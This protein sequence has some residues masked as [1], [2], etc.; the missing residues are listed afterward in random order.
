MLLDHFANHTHRSSIA[1]HGLAF[2]VAGLGLAFMW[3]WFLV[4]VALRKHQKTDGLALK[5][6]PPIQTTPCV[7]SPIPTDWEKCEPTTGEKTKLKNKT[8]IFFTYL[9]SLHVESSKWTNGCEKCSLLK[10]HPFLKVSPGDPY[11]FSD[12]SH[13]QNIHVLVRSKERKP[14]G[15]LC[16]RWGKTVED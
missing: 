16:G 15:G 14:K 12:S 8:V 11:V 4:N 5:S 13:H 9:K 10:Q 6:I 7:E 1:R 2:T 3:L